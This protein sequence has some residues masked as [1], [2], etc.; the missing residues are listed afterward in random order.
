M[1]KER[2]IIDGLWRCLCPSADTSI[3]SKLIGP[4]RN[5][6][7]RPNIPKSNNTSV[8]DRHGRREYHR[9][10]VRTRIG[11]TRDGHREVERSRAEYLERLAKRSPWIPRVLFGSVD[12]F[13]TKLDEIPTKT[14]YAAL[15]E[16]PRAS[17][18]HLSVVKL[19]EYLVRERKEKPNAMLYESLIRANVDRFHGSAEV[20][21]E[22]LKE[23]DRLGIPTT[24]QIYQALLEVNWPILPSKALPANI[25]V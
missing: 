1:P 13:A 9:A 4:T 15:K 11:Q 20:A 7:Q 10:V 24:P 19:V 22:L 14:I 23:M 2:I 17:G 12:T 6:R 3:L 5:P 25:K 16:L 21:G 8:T 18:T